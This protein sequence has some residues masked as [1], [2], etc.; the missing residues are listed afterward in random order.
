ME[1]GESS[2]TQHQGN[3]STADTRND[4]NQTA[5]AHDITPSQLEQGQGSTADTKHTG[6]RQVLRSM[7]NASKSL[8]PRQ[9]TEA[10]REERWA[11]LTDA[12]VDR[13][14]EAGYDAD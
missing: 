13:A 7:V 12:R 8:G 4:D 3:G 5:Y 1:R 2:G 14:E 10:E 6:C 9:E 11:R